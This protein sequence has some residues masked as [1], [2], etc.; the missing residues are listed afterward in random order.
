MN[1]QEKVV[2]ITKGRQR[3]RGALMTL[4]VGDTSLEIGYPPMRQHPSSCGLVSID[5][6][7]SFLDTSA[8][9]DPETPV[10]S[11]MQNNSK[12]DERMLPRY[13]ITEH[14]VVE[15]VAETAEPAGTS[16]T[17]SSLEELQQI[18]GQWPLSRLVEIWNKLPRARAVARFENRQVAARRLW[19]A[20]TCSDEQPASR[21]RRRRA[22]QSKTQLVLQMLRRPEGATLKALMKATRWQPH[23]VRGF[24]SAQVGKKLGLTLESSK[25]DGERVY[26]VRS[27][28][29]TLTGG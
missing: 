25:R 7:R 13:R 17:F 23:S 8:A 29:P 26:T 15:M 10:C 5:S 28:P 3:S 19:R 12:G 27:T 2:P 22:S 24:L 9:A 21:T 14:N 20:L 18:T 4:I 1:S 6:A 11:D 16:S